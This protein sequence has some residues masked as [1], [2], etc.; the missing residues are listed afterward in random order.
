MGIPGPLR[1]PR[2]GM[3]R[4]TTSQKNVTVIGREGTASN[5]ISVRARGITGDTWP[6]KDFNNDSVFSQ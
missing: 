6:S 3:R 2:N 5:N 4:N 1:E